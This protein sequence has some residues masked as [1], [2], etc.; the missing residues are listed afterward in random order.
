MT[1]VLILAALVA[2][3][4]AGCAKNVDKINTTKWGSSFVPGS[5]SRNSSMDLTAQGGSSVGTA[6]VPSGENNI[7]P[8]ASVGGT[9]HRTFAASAHYRM[10]GGFHVS[11]SGK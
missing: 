8:K 11:G 5:S 9:Y 7:I 4:A 1:R 2:V 6:T 10:V 3:S